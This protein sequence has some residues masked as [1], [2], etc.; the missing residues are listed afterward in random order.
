MQTSKKKYS[1][2]RFITVFSIVFLVALMCIGLI[3]YIV[4]PFFQFRAKPDTRYF[5]NPRFVTGG[6]AKSYDYNTVVLGSSMVQNYNLNILRNISAGYKPVKLSTGGM[7]CMEMEYIYSFIKK[8]QVKTFII[9]ID[10]PQFNSTF[11]EV[12]YPQYLY[13]DGIINKLKYLFGYETFV[14]FVPIDIGLTLYLKDKNNL[15]PEYDMKTNIDNI[16][17]S[18]LDVH[19]GADYVKQLYLSGWTVSEQ[20]LE[21]MGSRMRTRLDSMLVRMSPDKYPDAEYIFVMPPYSALYWYHTKQQGYYNW[22]MEFTRYISKSM[23]KY[24]NVRIAFFFDIDEI[25]DLDYYADIT[26]FN[27]VISDKILK[28]I[29]NPA[30]T[31]DSSDIE[32]RLQKVDSLVN[33]FVKQNKDWLK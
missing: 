18:S 31:L 20:L 21:D 23:S 28:N 24:N 17:N 25:T 3:S 10:I 5:L 30:Y 22:F 4:D 32:Y 9:N 11:E 14:Q 29:N 33:M 7:N 6:L 12:R 15:S 2:K 19:Y 16:G 1:S 8:E 13:E 27:P 26:H